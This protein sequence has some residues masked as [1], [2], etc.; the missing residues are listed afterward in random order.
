M[1]WLAFFLG[2]DP[3]TDGSPSGTL[4]N[5][6]DHDW[7]VGIVDA[8]RTGDTAILVDVRT[9]EHTGYERVVFEFDTRVPSY[10]LEYVDKP[11][12]QCGSGATVDLPGD[13]WL[14]VDFEDAQAHDDDGQATVDDYDF[15]L[16]Y[17]VIERVTSVCDFEGQVT[18]IVSVGTPNPYRVDLLDSPP[19]LVL[20]VESP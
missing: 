17:D 3:D 16:G 18:W 12:Y 19:R 11:I 6:V 8:D 10:H 1:L 15:E 14:E 5:T 2:C 7:T 4:S 13:A 20:D 9:G